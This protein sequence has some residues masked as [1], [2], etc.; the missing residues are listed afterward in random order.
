MPK[1][2]KDKILLAFSG[3]LDTSFC[4][5]YLKNQGYDV[6]TATVDSGGFSKNELKE[7]EQKSKT[8]GA[9]EHHTI[10]AKQELF[11]NFIAYTIKANALRG[12]VYPLSASCERYIQASKVVELAVKKGIKKIAHGSTGAGNDQIRYYLS[13]K[14]LAP[15]ME[16]I[17]PIRNLGTT[18][19]K[20]A[21][22]LKNHGFDVT[23]KTSEYS[24]NKGF[25]GNTIGGKETLDS[26]DC[27]P[28][29]VYPESKSP[30]TAPNTP[31]M[32]IIGFV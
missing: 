31:E 8:L 13:I 14:N 25:M 19:E 2:Q 22:Y 10:N 23:R 5:V 30:E 11:D 28:D 3:G 32:L 12:G 24:I 1:K 4:V 17:T 21:D 29:D 18:R 20:E 26:W 7:I 15:E 16:I 6:I 9:I 27:P